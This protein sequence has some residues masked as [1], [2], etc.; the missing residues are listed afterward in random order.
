MDPLSAPGEGAQRSPGNQ[1]HRASTFSTQATPRPNL[2]RVDSSSDP[3]HGYYT[4]FSNSST[5][6]QTVPIE[7][8]RPFT[9]GS[10]TSRID[11]S[12]SYAETSSATQSFVSMD[13]RSG[14]TDTPHPSTHSVHMIPISSDQD[15][16]E[17]GSTPPGLAPM[18]SGNDTVRQ[19]APPAPRSTVLQPSNTP[20]APIEKPLPIASHNIPREAPKV[21]PPEVPAKAEA[22]PSRKA[23]APG[24]VPWINT[25]QQ[26][27][28]STQGQK[29]STSSRHESTVN[30]RPPRSS[31][32]TISPI[33]HSPPP[34]EPR[35]S[36]INSQRLAPA[37][38]Q[39]PPPKVE[40]DRSSANGA[41][42]ADAPRPPLPS[43]VSQMETKY[44]NML[45]ALDGIPVC[46]LLNF[47]QFTELIQCSATP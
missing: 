37:P 45:L 31:D 47:I 40:P 30:A 44:V 6:P 15:V 18:E 4:T 10:T 17:E 35:K 11:A 2:E 13:S 27:A 3:G 24:P 26:V 36:T 14:P 5:E 1:R 38:V 16:E 23:E 7:H 33:K 21:S 19:S 34:P 29:V 8:L 32:A 41:A 25:P 12:R 20:P 28:P 43:T 22:I 9:Q 42:S 39:S 46:L